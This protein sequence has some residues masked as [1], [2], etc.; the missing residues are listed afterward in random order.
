MGRLAEVAFSDRGLR[1][2]WAEVLSNDE[3]DGELSGGVRRFGDRLDEELVRLS[4]DLAWAP[5]SPGT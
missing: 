2:A 5:T 1:H 4:A 3:A